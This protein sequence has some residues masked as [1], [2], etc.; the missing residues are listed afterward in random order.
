MS[1]RTTI[2]SV[3]LFGNN[4]S[5]PQWIEFI[6]SQGISVDADGCYE[7]DITDFMGAVKAVEEIVM[8]LHQQRELQ[9]E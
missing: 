8:E 2:E 1:Y 3:Q 6:K 9:E 5:Y 7:G 4:E